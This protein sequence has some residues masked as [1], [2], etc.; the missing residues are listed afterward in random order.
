MRTVQLGHP[1]RRPTALIG[2]LWEG[3]GFPALTAFQS[4]D[5]I[6]FIHSAQSSGLPGELPVPSLTREFVLKNR[7]QMRGGRR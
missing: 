1:E 6:A 3:D 2:R 7:P 5:A 4:W